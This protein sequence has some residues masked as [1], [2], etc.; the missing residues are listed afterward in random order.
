MKKTLL[1]ISA[2]L[3][4]ASIYA[5]N[6]PYDQYGNVLL[7]DYENYDDNQVVKITVSISDS[8]GTGVGWGVGTIKPINNTTATAAYSFNSMAVSPE[9]AEN[10]YEITIALFKDFAKV[11]GVY[12]EDSYGQKGVTINLYNAASLVSI[13]VESAAANASAFDFE[14]D[15][16]G[17]SYGTAGYNADEVSAIVTANPTVAGEKSLHL[18]ATN[19]RSY[20]KFNVTLPE[21]TTITDI[22]KVNFDIYFLHAEGETA[23]Y[24]QNKYKAVDCLIGAP[25][26]AFVVDAPQLSISNLIGGEN[27]NV[28]ISKV[29]PFASLTNETL[30]ALNAF[31]FAIG[32]NH[33]KIDLY[34]DNI[35][36]ILK[37]TQSVK[38]ANIDAVKI[39][40]VEG[41]IMVNA[42]NVPVTVY[43]I[44]GKAVKTQIANGS[45]IAVEKGFYIV[46]TQETVKKVIVK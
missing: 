3:L 27:E 16:I 20:A 40:G 42:E 39:Y 26:T 7:S 35:T 8:S 17:A 44:D 1:F 2:L 14:A 30:L 25:G 43:S 18:V 11:D 21:G 45:V 9:G 37:E 10:V 32:I 23:D 4:S 22:E 46:K 24:P 41:G 28:W 15:E 19:Y 38:N 29:I 31:D 33:E 5:E 34:L 6:I 13:T 12:Y 36:F